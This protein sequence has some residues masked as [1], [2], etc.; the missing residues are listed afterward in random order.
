MVNSLPCVSL[1]CVR[2]LLVG[3]LVLLLSI[4]V[5]AVEPVKIGVLA[6]RAKPQTLAQW[7]PLALALKRAIPERDFIIEALSNEEME[8]AVASRQLDF[9]LTNPGNYVVMSKRSGLSSPLASLSEEINGRAVNVF[10]GTIFCRSSQEHINT[11]ADLAGKTIASTSAESFGGYQMQAYEL[12]RVGVRLS[13]GAKL[14]FTGLPQDGVVEA[15]LSGRAEVGFVRSGLLESMAREGSLDMKQLK[16]INRQNL[17]GFS[18]VVSTHLYPGWPFAALPHIDGNLSRRVAAALF[19]LEENSADARAMQIRGFDVPADYAPVVALLQQL[20]LPPFDVP[21]EFNLRDVWQQYRWWVTASLFAVGLILLLG[22]GLWLSNRRLRAGQRRVLQQQQRIQENEH[23]LDAIIEHIPNM[24][25]VKDA[26]QLKFVRFNSAGEKLLGYS[27]DE[28]IGKNDYD[29]FP[30]EQAD[31]FT[32]KDREIIAGR[33]LM[34]IPEES[35]S[36]K[37]SGQRYLHTRKIPILTDDGSPRYLLGIS[38]DITERKQAE[39]AIRRLNAEL[40][41]RVAQRTAQLEAANKELEEFSYSMSHDMRTP[42]RALDGFSKILLEEHSACL[43]DEGKRLL[44]VLRDSAQHMGRLVDDIL[45]YLSMGRRRME[46][47]AVDIAKLAAEIIA[48]LQVA[49]PARRLRLEIGTLPPAW[50]DGDMLREVLQK[51]LS[52]AVKF[53]PADGEV[54]IEIGGETQQEENIYSVRDHGIGFDMSYVNKL[55]RVFERVHPTGQYKGSG[56]GLAIVKRII[57][58]HGGRVWAEGKLN[59][60]AT[61]YF[62]LPTKENNHGQ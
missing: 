16:I 8:N 31:F 17:P 26:E 39:E 49:A 40:E 52:N 25:F 62:A 28:L 20:R 23:F 48:E 58:R 60:G 24:V 2:G 50:G 51:L 1:A 30:K 29:F 33:K 54:S 44:G 15:V 10:G 12:S 6:F 9:V 43:D 41:Q 11:L 55:F 61:I 4:P 35:I 19:S 36:T 34:D 56:I 22:Y 38:E 14:L 21:P 27:R 18:S 37:S 13:R 47:G 53:S 7:Q 3:L 57:I 46:Y 45:H 59:E 42:L 32:S 5:Y